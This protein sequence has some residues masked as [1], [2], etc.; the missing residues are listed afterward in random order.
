[1]LTLLLGRAG[2]GKSTT[3]LQQMKTNGI[4]RPQVM[5]VPEQSSY[6]MERLLCEKNGNT[7]GFYAEVISFTNLANR[8]FSLYGGLAAPELDE[9]GRL[10]VMYE[11]LK[12]VVHRLTVFN[13]PA[14]K[15]EFLT[16]LLST[17]DELK[18]CCISVEELGEIAEDADGMSKEKLQDL[19]LVYGA[20]ETLTARGPMDPRDRPTRLAEKL[21]DH[22]Y[23]KGKDVYLDG[24]TDFTAQEEIVLQEILRQAHTMTVTLTCDKVALDREEEFSFFL[25]VRKTAVHFLKMAEKIGT[26][27]TVNFLIKDSTPQGA[28]LVQLEQNLFS[29]SPQIF[30]H[31]TQD[32]IFLLP[33][34]SRRQEVEWAADQIIRFVRSGEFRYREITVTARNMEPYH[35]LIE[36]VFESRG[37]PVY[38]AEMTDILQKP[39]FTLIT[40]ALDTVTNH[41]T[42]EDIFRYLKTGLTGI[43]QD[44]CDELENYVLTWRIHGTKWTENK[45]WNF[46]PGGYHQQPDEADTALLER[47]NRIRYEVTKPLEILRKKGEDSARDKV[48]KLYKF[49]ELAGVPDKLA[50]RTT[51]LLELGEPEM[52]QE[53]GQLWEILCGALEQCSLLLG[54]MPIELEEFSQLLRLLLSQYSVGSIPASLDRVTVG[55]ATRLAN[56]RTK[57]LFFIGADDNSI[58]QISPG[59]GL[60]SDMDRELLSEHGLPIGEKTE[61]KFAREFNILYLVCAQPQNKL[62]VTWPTTGDQGTENRPSFLVTWLCRLF[63]NLN[64]PVQHLDTKPEPPSTT[65]EALVQ[66]PAMAEYFQKIP[67]FA[68]VVQLYARAVQGNRGHLSASAVEGLYGSR[69]SMSASRLDQYKSCHFSYFMRYG[70]KARARKAA[71]FDA[72]EYGTFI[73]YV[74][75][76]VLIEIRNDGG[77]SS[78]SDETVKK[79]TRQA[80]QRYIREKLGGMENQ[81]ARFCYLFRRLQRSVSL[82]VE[83]VIAEL[84]SSDFQPISFELGF[85]TG[86]DLPPVQMKTAGITLSISGFVDR[87]DGW[88]KDNRLYLRV[89]DYKTGRKSFDLTEIWNGLGLQMLLYL[90]TLEEKGEPLF[91]YRITPAGV[92]YLPAREAVVS[93]S[94]EM[95]EVQRQ[96]MV[97]RELVRSGLLLE[98]PKVIEAMEIPSEAGIR[99]LPVRVQAKTGKI[100]GDA[101]VSAQKLGH[102][103]KH[104]QKILADICREMANGTILADPFWRGPEKNACRFCEF[105]QACHFEDG[106]GEDRKRWIPS[107]KNSEFWD[108]IAKNTG[109]EDEDGPA[110]NS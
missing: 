4:K 80:V 97:D 1:M 41:Y 78:A 6:E 110:E 67:E 18:Q 66:Y 60:L 33:L 105:A 83:N 55:E 56:R 81:S 35:N 65:W 52:A 28:P 88:V 23:F 54:D 108:S 20:F 98:D 104:I 46:P 79:L 29:Q 17:I 63:P 14:K 95:D 61:E 34:A 64:L 91:G 51:R 107:V 84:R 15:T 16:G 22:P 19:T 92:L 11:A 89:V 10:L 57:V 94:R 32:S 47:L 36:R 71:S 109:G 38:H 74:L 50:E 45:S 59:Q 68:Q 93:G 86:Q 72:P 48:V 75:E 100:T 40:A 70:L 69:I 90:F 106:L 13:L 37:I 7:S 42:Y 58:P 102:L 49:L 8:M 26:P 44:D 3:I 96:K 43:S 12:S 76:H 31:K 62:M 21:K 9:G 77:V 73:H 53:Y 5:L 25:P 24:F 103:K 99:F 101:L 2:C 85:D 30:N 87:V 39:I 82:V 27:A